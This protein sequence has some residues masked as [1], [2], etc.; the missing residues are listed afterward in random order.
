[1]SRV[2]D[3]F[4]IVKTPILYAVSSGVLAWLVSCEINWDGGAFLGDV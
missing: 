1:M 2:V 3:D 4:W